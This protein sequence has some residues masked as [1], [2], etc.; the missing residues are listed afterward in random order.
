MLNLCFLA[1]FNPERTAHEP[2]F[3]TVVIDRT[4]K[5]RKNQQELFCDFP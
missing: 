3:T 2:S 1:S 4:P 5:R